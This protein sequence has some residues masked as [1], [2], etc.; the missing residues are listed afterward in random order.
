MRYLE[1]LFIVAGLLLESIEEE[2]EICVCGLGTCSCSA[3]ALPRAGTPSP[4]EVN[5]ENSAYY[6]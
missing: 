4:S 5:T 1:E 6:A 2:A 3:S